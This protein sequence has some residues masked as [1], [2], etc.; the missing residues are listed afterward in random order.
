MVLRGKD[1]TRLALG[2]RRH[3][4]ANLDAC[5]A[6]RRALLRLPPAQRRADVAPRLGREEAAA[7]RVVQHAA[8]TI[9]PV[10]GEAQPCE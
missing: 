5:S 4:A 2:A 10:Q 9:I 6:E 3:R 1:H 7:A 8:R